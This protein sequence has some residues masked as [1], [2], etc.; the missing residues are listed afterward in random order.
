MKRVL[1][2]LFALAA[3]VGLSLAQERTVTGVVTDAASGKPLP[4][5]NIQIKGTSSGT[6]T[7]AEGRYTVRVAGPETVLVFFSMGYESKEVTEER[8]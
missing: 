8:D 4:L 2:L 6:V 1:L 7:D 3:S 5:V